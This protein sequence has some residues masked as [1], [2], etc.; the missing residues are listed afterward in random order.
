LEKQ[1]KD[2]IIKFEKNCEMFVMNMDNL[3]NGTKIL[4]KNGVV[5]NDI[6][7]ENTVWDEKTKKMKYIDLGSSI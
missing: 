1:I 3:F 5:H 7:P 6:K 4:L 2:N